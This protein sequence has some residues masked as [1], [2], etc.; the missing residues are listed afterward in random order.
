MYFALLTSPH[1]RKMAIHFLLG[2]SILPS[3]GP[4]IF[5]GQKNKATKTIKDLETKNMFIPIIFGIFSVL[6]YI[7][8]NIV[9]R[10]ITYLLIGGCLGLFLSAL[11]KFNYDLPKTMF[12]Y[13]PKNEYMYYLAS[14]G[15]YAVLFYATVR[16]LMRLI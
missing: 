2:S 1:V 5:L 14:F 8:M 12:G 15:I 11:G 9:K 7:L 4:M 13:E 16:P 3:I 6:A 10:E